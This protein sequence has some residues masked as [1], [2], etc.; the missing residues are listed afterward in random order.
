MFATF[1]AVLEVLGIVIFAV[2]GALVASRK[3]LDIISFI[4]FGTITGVGGGTIR[5][6]L[7]GALPVFWIRE[8]HVIALCIGV[9]CLMFF[10]A[11]IPK[12]RLRLLL[13]LDA[14]GL[15]L[16]SVTG[17]ETA[18]MAGVGP[19]SRSPWVW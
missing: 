8:P 2:T 15:A 3:Q 16:F 1:T 18:M 5:D 10:V 19:S 7:T 14:L 4:L 17:A 9:S 12:S 11:H 6:V 13:W